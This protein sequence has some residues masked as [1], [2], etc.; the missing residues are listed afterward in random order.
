MS[1]LVRCLVLLTPFLLMAEDGLS[2]A[3]PGKGGG[4]DSAAPSSGMSMIYMLPLVFG[5]MYFIVIRPQKKE[6]KKRK[7][8]M[9][10]LRRGDQV[11]TIG[12][13]HGEVESVGEDTVDLT[14]NVSGAASVLRF[15]KGAIASRPVA[16]DK[17]DA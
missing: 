17:K 11:V 12:G 8:L 13:L 7:A 15:N 9:G 3:A 14:V 4:P 16:D 1:F 2:P 10:A 6:E 5:L